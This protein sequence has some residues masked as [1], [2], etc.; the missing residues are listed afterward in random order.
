LLRARGR[1]GEFAASGLRRIAAKGRGGSK[2]PS[3]PAVAF[4]SVVPEC[5]NR[6]SSGFCLDSKKLVIARI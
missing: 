1:G 3:S 6:E 5:L 2:S 4:L